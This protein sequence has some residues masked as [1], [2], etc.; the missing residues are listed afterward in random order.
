MKLHSAVFQMFLSL[1]EHICLCNKRKSIWKKDCLEKRNVTKIYYFSN[2]SCDFLYNFNCFFNH[3]FANITFCVFEWN[4]SL[5]DT[6]FD[7]NVHKHFFVKVKFSKNVWIER[8]ALGKI[9]ARLPQEFTVKLEFILSI[10]EENR[11]LTDG[12]P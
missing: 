6:P 9:H 2:F 3:N 1:W 12:L 4:I 11:I 7:Q 10:I 8:V 5:N